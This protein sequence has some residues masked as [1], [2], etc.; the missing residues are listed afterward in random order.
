MIQ[1]AGDAT[2]VQS[3]SSSHLQVLGNMLALVALSGEGGASLH[4]PT[5]RHL[6]RN[7]GTIFKELLGPTALCCDQNVGTI[8]KELAG[9]TALCCD[10]T[11]DVNHRGQK[12]PKPLLGFPIRSD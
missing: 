6:W 9:P 4:N 2:N 7:V 11:T 5:Q 8:F 10:Q 1:W 3:Q 12:P